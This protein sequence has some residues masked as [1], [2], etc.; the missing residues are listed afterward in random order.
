MFSQSTLLERFLPGNISSLRQELGVESRSKVAADGALMKPGA[1]FENFTRLNTT[2]TVS[3]CV[4]HSGLES[5]NR[6]DDL[7]T[8]DN[9]RKAIIRACSGYVAVD[10]DD[11]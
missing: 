1:W 5:T 10:P 9:T 2:A 3:A 6:R 11:G 7:L 4:R 8:I